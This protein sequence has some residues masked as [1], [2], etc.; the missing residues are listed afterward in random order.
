MPLYF[1]P[2][3]L[4]SAW[5]RTDR[6]SPSSD[7]RHAPIRPV[8][9][10]PS[11]TEPFCAEAAA[12]LRKLIAAFDDPARAYLAQPHPGRLPRFPQYGQ[13]ARVAEWRAVEDGE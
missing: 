12:S 5:L 2:D 10:V 13:L 6:P 7:A 1:S 8:A 11:G 9:P 3:D 4:G